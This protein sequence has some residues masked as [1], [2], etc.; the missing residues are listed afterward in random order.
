[1][2][3]IDNSIKFKCSE[4]LDQ[5]A[6]RDDGCSIP[7]DTKGQA[8][9]GSEWPALDVGVPVYCRDVGLDGL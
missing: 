2:L 8:E 9:L 3:N 7:G 6:Q 1:M 5:V 4:A